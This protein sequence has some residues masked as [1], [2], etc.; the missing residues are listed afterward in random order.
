[1]TEGSTVY[2]CTGWT[3]TGSVPASGGG[4]SVTFSVHNNSKITWNWQIHN[5]TIESQDGAGVQKDVFSLDET[6]CVV[7][8]GFVASQTFDVYIVYDTVWFD[9]VNITGRVQATA[10]SDSFGNITLTAVWNKPLASG[11]YGILVDV[12]GNGKYDA[13]VDAPYGNKVIVVVHVRVLATILEL[14]G[15]FAA[16]GAFLMYRRRHN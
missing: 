14:A 1:V 4:V 8:S 12:D 13:G 10:S 2:T 15:C 5:P 7:G 3:G 16:L 9:G 11:V 6:V